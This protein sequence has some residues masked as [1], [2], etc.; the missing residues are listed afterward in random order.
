MTKEQIQAKLKRNKRNKKGQLKGIKWYF[1]AL[2]RIALI[3][4]VSIKNRLSLR[5]NKKFS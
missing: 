4:E 3:D 5:F 1:N 2:G